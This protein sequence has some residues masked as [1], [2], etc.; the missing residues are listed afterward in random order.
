VVRNI[1]YPVC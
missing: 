1:T